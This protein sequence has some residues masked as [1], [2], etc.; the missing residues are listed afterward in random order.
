[1]DR[2]E[3]R[4]NE[5]ERR[6]KGRKKRKE[7][8]REEKKRKEK[9][10]HTRQDNPSQDKT[11]QIIAAWLTKHP[12]FTSEFVSQG[13]PALL[14]NVNVVGE[15]ARALKMMDLD[16]AR[17]LHAKE[18]CQVGPGPMFADHFHRW[19]YTPKN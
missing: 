10:K 3:E 9:K 14:R 18:V 6:K 7:K 1:M 19:S 13:P 8:R 11:R 15:T 16:F 4:Q 5:R 2:K 12:P 17:R